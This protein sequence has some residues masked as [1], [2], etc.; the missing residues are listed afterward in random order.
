MMPGSSDPRGTLD[1]PR[2]K[3][4]ASPLGVSLR[5]SR[6]DTSIRSSCCVCGLVA[7]LGN[8]QR[9]LFPLG[10]PW[11]PLDFEGCESARDTG[12]G[13][14]IRGCCGRSRFAGPHQKKVSG[15]RC[16]V[17]AHT[18]AH[19]HCLRQWL[20]TAASACHGARRTYE[21]NF[22]LHR[23]CPACRPARPP[24]GPVCGNELRMYGGSRD[25]RRCPLPAARYAKPVSY[26]GGGSSPIGRPL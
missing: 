15:I 1:G 21:T 23:A 4:E 18:R 16:R 10:P 5:V 8:F 26:V 2:G 3:G 20:G 22:V 17:Y 6:N 14:S 7:I 12:C 13:R 25:R 19:A 9:P 24:A 11:S